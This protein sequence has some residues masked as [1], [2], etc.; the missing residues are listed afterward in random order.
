MHILPGNFYERSFRRAAQ[1]MIEFLELSAF[2]FPAHP[3]I[4]LRV[5]LAFAME[6]EKSSASGPGPM[7]RVQLG[8]GSDGALQKLIVTGRRFGVRIGPVG[9]QRKPQIAVGIGEVMN[10]EVVHM[11]LGAFW[12]GKQGRNDHDC[13]QRVWHSGTEF[14]SWQG[15]RSEQIRDDAIGQS[16]RQIRSWN[17]REYPHQHQI[18]QRKS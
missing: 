12:R 7:P 14:H 10:F 4:F 3:F 8:D 9:E 2:S 5:P 11:S 13:S 15:A 17:R 6:Q 16:N 1:Q 18:R